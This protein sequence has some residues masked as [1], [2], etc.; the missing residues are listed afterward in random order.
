MKLPSQQWGYLYKYL[1]LV[2]TRCRVTG[3][4]VCFSCPA[5]IKLQLVFEFSS[6]TSEQPAAKTEVLYNYLVSHS[7]AGARSIEIT[8][9]VVFLW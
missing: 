9:M 5:Q 6:T 1:E 8:L 2:L 4:K 3:D 7:E